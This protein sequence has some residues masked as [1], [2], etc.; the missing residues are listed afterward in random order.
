VIKEL[1]RREGNGR[2]KKLPLREEGWSGQTTGGGVNEEEHTSFG[3]PKRSR[4]F[5]T[6]KK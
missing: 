2:A 6:V 4:L 1:K 5:F 3:K